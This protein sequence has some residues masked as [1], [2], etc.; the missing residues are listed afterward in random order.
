MKLTERT[1]FDCRADQ[2]YIKVVDRQI[3]RLTDCEI[4]GKDFNFTLATLFASDLIR[5]EYVRH[6]P[7]S[8]LASL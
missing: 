3:C 5:Y 6:A 1:L 2:H 4:F 7:I 8:L